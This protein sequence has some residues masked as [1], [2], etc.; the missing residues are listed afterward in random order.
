MDRGGVADIARLAEKALYEYLAKVQD[1]ASRVPLSRG[2]RERDPERLKVLS[3]L[4][5]RVRD[6]QRLLHSANLRSKS[7]GDES[8]R[9]R[10]SNKSS[11]TTEQSSSTPDKP[12]EDIMLAGIAARLTAITKGNEALK[13]LDIDAAW[14]LADAFKQDMLYIA[15]D[16]YL[17]GRLEAEADHELTSPREAWST[18]FPDMSFFTLIDSIKYGR[19]GDKSQS[20]DENEVKGGSPRSSSQQRVGRRKARDLAVRRLCFLYDQRAAA[21]RSHRMVAQIRSSYLRRLSLYLALFLAGVGVMMYV[22]G[23]GMADV[24][25]YVMTALA[26]A[27]GGTLAG[28]YKLRDSTATI[29]DLR[30]FDAQFFAMLALGASAAA[31]LLIFMRSGL[32]VLGGV[33]LAGDQAW[34][35]LAGI[36]FLAG[37]SEPFFLGTVE[38]IAG[39]IRESKK[40]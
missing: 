37:F 38:R 24:N 35:A 25:A 14:E 9:S 31:V 39:G 6:V 34:L 1:T 26:G 23:A 27:L 7:Q 8:Q 3:R 10:S 11:D 22:L 17:I 4:L 32:V 29:R 12:A 21:G 2:W 36:G 33:D 13:T 15:D 16:H 40:G 30:G 18:H 20:S 19:K 5:A 28:V